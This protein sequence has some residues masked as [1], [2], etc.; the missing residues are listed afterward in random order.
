MGIGDDANETA[1]AGIKR[2]ARSFEDNVD[3]AKDKIDEV[4]A[5]AK[6]KSAEAQRESV[7]KRN[8]TKEKLRD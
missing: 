1:Q 8:E 3:R 5:D 4:Q 2:V 7:S 6:V